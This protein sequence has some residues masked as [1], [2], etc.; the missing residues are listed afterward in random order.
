M[1]KLSYSLFPLLGLLGL[2]TLGSQAY[3]Q[4]AQYHTKNGSQETRINYEGAIT[5]NRAGTDIVAMEPGAYLEYQVNREKVIIKANR[6]GEITR[7][8]Y[9]KGRETSYEPEGRA[10]FEKYFPELVRNSGI[11]A[12]TRVKDIYAGEGLNAILKETE[13]LES[14]YVRYIYYK[15]LLALPLKSSQETKSVLASI[16]ETLDSDYYQAKILLNELSERKPSIEIAREILINTQEIDSDYEQHRVLAALVKNEEVLATEPTLF[17]QALDQIKSDY[18]KSKIVQKMMGQNID[19]PDVIAFILSSSESIRSSYESSRVLQKLVS[20]GELN[21][22]QWDILCTRASQVDS[23][24]EKHKIAL[25]IIKNNRPE[26]EAAM[27][28]FFCLVENIRS[29]YNQAQSLL[30]YLAKAG[31]DTPWANNII[32]ISTKVNSDYEQARILLK[33]SEANL[34]NEHILA[35]LNASQSINSNYEKARVL[36]KLADKQSLNDEK[37]RARFKEVASTI[38][39]DHEYGK[40]M[41][42]LEE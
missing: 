24:Y 23:D 29:D 31:S 18:Y 38:K 10:F 12:K 11:G 19:N 20:L 8:Y 28:S 1:K 41:R 26:E 13:R 30:T 32:Q 5:L 25:S 14:D 17:F 7:S 21:A 33:L 6:Q 9:V 16:R 37:V 34:N 35:F 27:K 15:H 39:S 4:K 40:V 42:A 36:Y 3:A 2:L 22:Q